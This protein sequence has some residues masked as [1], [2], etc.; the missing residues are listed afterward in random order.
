MKSLKEEIKTNLEEAFFNA[1]RILEGYCDLTKRLK[2]VEEAVDD[3]ETWHDLREDP[4][5]LPRDSREVLIAYG[6]DDYGIG[7]YWEGTEG[8][9]NTIIPVIAWKYIEPFK[10][11]V[12]SSK[13]RRN[14]ALDVHPTPIP[15]KE[16]KRKP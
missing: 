10:E 16:T 3:I 9:G 1:E 15:T 7:E 14:P 11:E 5:D 13:N 6:E 2:S 4:D 12:T 8:W